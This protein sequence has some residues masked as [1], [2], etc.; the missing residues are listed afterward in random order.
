[1]K[2]KSTDCSKTTTKQNQNHNNLV[3]TAFGKRTIVNQNFSKLISL[4]K[5]ALENLGKDIKQ[6]NVE[7]V[8]ENNSKYIR[9]VPITGGGETK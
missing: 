6:V 1:M 3:V 2:A 8:Q 7:L 4:P 9:L 5:T